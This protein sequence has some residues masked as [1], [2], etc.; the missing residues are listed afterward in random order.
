MSPSRGGRLK[1]IFTQPLAL[2]PELFTRVGLRGTAWGGFP[3]ATILSHLWL[4]KSFRF[5]KQQVSH[6]VDEKVS[7]LAH[8]EFVCVCA[9]KPLRPVNLSSCLRVPFR[10]PDAEGFLLLAYLLQPLLIQEQHQGVPH[11]HHLDQLMEDPILFSLLLWGLVCQKNTHMENYDFT[12]LL[13]A[14]QLFL[15]FLSFRPATFLFWFT[16]AA[17]I[18]PLSSKA[19]KKLLSPP[20]THS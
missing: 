4:L 10:L 2:E 7:T 20:L 15:S 14:F 5:W 6:T 8:A 1:V 13:S 11:V 9:W 19:A 3:S 12:E 18:V 16:L 17:L